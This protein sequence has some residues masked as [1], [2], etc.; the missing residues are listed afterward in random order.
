MAGI[1]FQLARVAREGGVGGIA[2]A[3]VHGAVISSGPWLLTAAGMILLERWTAHHLH[4]DAAH[5]V[6]TVLI[7]AF[8][9]SALAAAP[10]GIV[11]TRLVADR[12]FAR[13]SA[14]IP[15]I[16]LT[17]LAAGGAIGLTVGLALFAGLGRLPPATALLSAVT[18]AWLTQIW[19][20]APM[21]TTLDRFRAVPAAYL[22]GI[23]V[24]T[25]TL[26]LRPHA[27]ATSVLAV[28]GI[29]VGTTLAAILMLL[30]RHFTGDAVLPAPDAMPRR[31]ATI[32]SLAGIAG[33]TAIWIDKWILW[34]GPESGRA[35]GLLRLNPIND[36]GSFL[37]LLTIV[38]G[39][40]LLLIVTETRFD[41]AFG[42]M[43]AR[44]T[45]TSTMERIEEARTDLIRVMLN[46][47][48]LLILVQLLVA[49]L[50][51]VLA[52]P[53]F[54][55]IGADVRA[56]FAFR[57]T[58]AGVVFHLIAI[59]TTVVLAYYDLFGR[60]LAT[61]AGFAIGSA[62]ATWL[63]FDAGLAAFGWGYMAGAVVGA[64]VGIAM[65]AEASVNLTYLLF[66]GNNPAV[67]GNGGRWL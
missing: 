4:G 12:L 37:G 11:A 1:G 23:L 49:A 53:L 13:D 28:V 55:L 67:V 56:I 45:G 9:L 46:G 7:Y 32:I 10:I 19:I 42:S 54:D 27:G 16:L 65:V 29:G 57:Q 44:C 52:V 15:G 47:I 66:V 51:W 31:L 60:I 18:L 24:A 33:V 58:S 43:L 2:A 61:W 64:S 48:R 14:A 26:L 50:A 20:A 41:R 17:A 25:G 63:Q 6:Q 62:I 40:T 22:L 36:E 3:A 34:F 38:P 21:L 30:R 39:L 8:S 59:A 35:L 5:L